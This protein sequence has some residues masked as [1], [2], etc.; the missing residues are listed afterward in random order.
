MSI[1]E[2]LQHYRALINIWS[3]GD[4]AKYAECKNHGA[5]RKQAPVVAQNIVGRITRP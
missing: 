1:K 4:V 3:L 2:T 5:V